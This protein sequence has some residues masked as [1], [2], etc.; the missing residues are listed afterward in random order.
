MRESG[1][2]C[3]VCGVRLP[4]PHSPGE[5]RCVACGGKHRVYMT[6][7]LQ[8][9][10]YCQFLEEDCRTPLPRKLRF[11]DVKKVVELAQRCGALMNLEAR[12]AIDHAIAN[13]RG[14]MWL[15]LTEEQYRKLKTRLK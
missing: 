6:F 5:R 7:F 12:Q 10:W 9:G 13:G 3:A 4:A 8:R 15:E 1:K 11:K 14:G 2:I